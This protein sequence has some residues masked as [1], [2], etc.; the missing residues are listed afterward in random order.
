MRIERRPI[1]RSVAKLARTRRSLRRAA[2][3][4]AREATMTRQAV[5]VLVPERPA[6]GEKPAD[7]GASGNEALLTGELLVEEISID[8]RCGV[9]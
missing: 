8:G 3:G 4:P 1:I 6:A 2:A 9:Y 7:P 5:T